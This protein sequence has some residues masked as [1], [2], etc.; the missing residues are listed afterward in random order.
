MVTIYHP[1]VKLVDITNGNNVYV[2][3][4]R[5]DNTIRYAPNTAQRAT[6]TL[7]NLLG[8][9]TFSDIAPEDNCQIK[10]NDGSTDYLMFD[11]YITGLERIV[12]GYRPVLKIDL[13]D[14]GGYLAAKT[15]GET[16]QGKSTTAAALMASAAALIS[17]VTTNIDA[18]TTAIK[19][20]HN[21]T[22]AKD[23]L[24]SA[25]EI[26]GMDFFFDESKVLQAFNHS[27]RALQTGGVNY[28]VRDIRP[29]SGHAEHLMV[30]RA[31]NY[32]YSYALDANM[33]YRSVVYTNGIAH[34]FPNLANL[35]ALT[36]QY[37]W[38]DSIGK[39]FAN[40]IR[41][42][43]SDVTYDGL[44][45]AQPNT[46]Q[47]IA[48]D[49]NG[50]TVDTGSS[51]PTLRLYPASTS[52]LVRVK[53]MPV[54]ID[55]YVLTEKGFGI[56][57]DGTFTELRFFLRN[58]L[59]TATVTDL[60]LRLRDAN[61]DTSYW[62][63]KIKHS[64]GAYLDGSTISAYNDLTTSGGTWAYLRYY[65]PTTTSNSM[66]WSLSP[67]NWYKVGS[68]TTFNSFSIV[69]TPDSGYTGSIDL[70]QFYLYGKKRA[71]VTGSG[72]PATQKIIVNR[73]IK[74]LATLQNLAASEQARSNVVANKS[75]CSIFGNT[76]MTKPGYKIDIDFST[77][78]GSDATAT[79]IRMSG[80][81]H[82][83][84]PLWISS[85]EFDRPLPRA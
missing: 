33:R 24:K 8:D 70:A 50:L 53:I 6:I 16:A 40:N 77:T 26:G 15:V 41:L 74:H 18:N 51:I 30:C 21:G 34:T 38:F 31:G 49:S 2:A 52:Q 82:T 64:G 12:S 10:V 84:T 42:T 4:N 3:S 17:G 25:S 39:N 61:D 66:N 1:I 76:V 78:L 47:P 59:A 68:P 83:L 13:V 58:S 71:S 54:N 7:D 11:G 75:R 14:F 57:A 62:A 63:Y 80:I 48:I 35:H 73:S 27:G 79:G 37:F 56:P 72:S 5:D 44:P 67:A 23:M 28:K 60:E 45:Y 69:I 55:Q 22:Y 9:F 19:K 43:T 36:T 20:E 65:L 32:P 46:V 85:I 29:T 81:H